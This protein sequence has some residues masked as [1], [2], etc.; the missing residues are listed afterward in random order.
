[1]RHRLFVLPLVFLLF[2]CGIEASDDSSEDTSR[3]IKTPVGPANESGGG[4]HHGAVIS[5]GSVELDG[6]TFERRVLELGI[7]DGEWI[8]VRSG[9]AAGERVVSSGATL[10]KLASANPDAFGAGHA[11]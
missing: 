3:T 1:M 8:E 6:E 9:V 11:H 10:V 2:S 5:L 4:S 7:R